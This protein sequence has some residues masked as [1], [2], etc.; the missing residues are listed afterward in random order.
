MFLCIGG[1]LLSGGGN[2]SQIKLRL[3]V[4]RVDAVLFLIHVGPLRA[5]G[6]EHGRVTQQH[7]AQAGELQ[8]DC[9]SVPE[10]PRRRRDGSAGG[11]SPRAMTW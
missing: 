8:G 4:E 1:G 5:A 11:K 6:A 9:F 7:V 10:R 3:P 2:A